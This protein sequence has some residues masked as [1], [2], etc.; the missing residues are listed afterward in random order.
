MGCG[1]CAASFPTQDMDDL[2]GLVLSNRYKLTLPLGEGSMGW[3]Y[4]ALHLA[5]QKNVAVKIMKPSGRDMG[6]RVAR[7]ERE[8]KAASR[9]NNPH[10]I[11]V[12]DFGQ[13]PS[14]MLYL[15]TEHLNGR[16]LR[17]VL[18]DERILHLE[19]S[20]HIL[21]QILE[22][23]SE[24]H[25]LGVVH[26]D[27]KP[28]NVMITDLPSGEDFVKVLD[29]GIAKV[30]DESSA[31]LTLEGQLF[32]TPEYMSPEQIRCHDI[33]GQA[34]LYSAGVIL[35][36][37]LTGRRPFIR[38][39]LFDLLHAH[40]HDPPP[41]LMDAAPGRSYPAAL[42]KVLD[43]ML[44]KSRSDRFATADE[45]RKAL[46]SVIRMGSA[47]LESLHHEPVRD[48]LRDRRDSL[49]DHSSFPTMI[50]SEAL[51]GIERLVN[52]EISVLE[53]VGDDGI[54][55]S[56]LAEK[57]RILAQQRGFQ[58]YEVEPDPEGVP[59]PWGPV[60]RI[61]GELLDL[62]ERPCPEDL[63][64]SLMDHP[65][66][67]QERAGLFEM[68][69]LEGPLVHAEPDIRK[70]EGLSAF[71]RAFL[72]QEKR[73]IL[74]LFDDLDRYDD[75]SRRA[76]ARLANKCRGTEVRMLVTARMPILV[77]LIGKSRVELTIPPDSISSLN[78]LKRD[79]TLRLGL[80][81]ESNSNRTVTDLMAF[82][83]ARLPASILRIVQAFG[84]LGQKAC[85]EELIY[86]LTSGHLLP[87][88]IEDLKEQ[89]FLEQAPSEPFRL[90]HPLWVPVIRGSLPKR[91]RQELN[92]MALLLR[93]EQNAPA[94]VQALHAV[95]AGAYEDAVL[96]LTKAGD[97]AMA[98]LEAKSAAEFFKK[99]VDVAR[100]KLLLP[101]H[102]TDFLKLYWK[103]GEALYA[104]GDA[105][106]ARMVLASAGTTTA[107]SDISARIKRTL[108]QI[109]MG[110]EM[111]T[112]ALDLMEK[113][114]GEAIQVGDPT[115]ITELYLDL[116]NLLSHM[117]LLRQA[118]S[119]LAEGLDMVTAGQDLHEIPG[120]VGLWRLLLALGVLSVSATA[121]AQTLKQAE[122]WA[123][124]ALSVAQQHGVLVGMARAFALMAE[125][126]RLQGRREEAARSRE[127][128]LSV[129]R[130]LG[131][132]KGQ[133]NCLLALA[134]IGS[135]SHEFYRR[136]AYNLGTEVEWCEELA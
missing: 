85:S 133:A 49:L 8:A 17:E 61:V 26:R 51:E 92:H 38:D 104:A 76:V 90:T 81:L 136:R 74:I 116:G 25:C 100:W 57:A 127:D 20:V 35:F 109:R 78:P 70:C 105:L 108:A 47:A 111:P 2:S 135:G 131:D 126:K 63:Y 99:A 86:L 134:R 66:L 119:E 14:G 73:P 103:L 130:K 80:D 39:S 36:E 58:V 6:Q 84:V 75:A 16:S 30:L 97:E 59:V 132:R 40:L 95:E 98:A 64:G 44:A 34:D 19:R 113:A 89:G 117:G 60:R 93:K 27:L 13:G 120:K 3:V 71:V 128:A 65:E 114:V 54:G 29:F 77:D 4:Q 72:L 125:I 1:Q 83:L 118:A 124:Q 23:L 94:A 42:Q 87:R 56:T 32:G 5:L 9:L 107:P 62:P 88:S 55:K 50:F 15:V 33:T 12:L 52:G 41:T 21:F 31:N 101:E 91:V 24:S 45:L 110:E 121:D 18:D 10:I 67:A 11:S 69:G 112:K 79:Q 22:A 106:S 102:S 129:L 68:F 123:A 37:M 7:F 115:L 48:E 96:L 53:I 82:R 122:R 46:R 28:E 43:R